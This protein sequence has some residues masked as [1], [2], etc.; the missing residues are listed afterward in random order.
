[1]V[2]TPQSLDSEDDSTHWTSSHTFS[3]IASPTSHANGMSTPIPPHHYQRAAEAASSTSTMDRRSTDSDIY[4]PA[5]DDTA[6]LYTTKHFNSP[7]SPPSSISHYKSNDTLFPPTSDPSAHL[8]S[9]QPYSLSYQHLPSNVFDNFSDQTLTWDAF[10][11][12]PAFADIID[13]KSFFS[14]SNPLPTPK[15]GSINLEESAPLYPEMNARDMENGDSMLIATGMS[16]LQQAC[17]HG[18]EIVVQLLLTKGA[19]LDTKDGNGQ[20]T[21]HI[22]ARQGRQSVTKLLLDQGAN[23]F[24]QDNFG[25]TPLHVASR[26]GHQSIVRLLLEG[27]GMDR[28]SM[29][30][31][32]FPD[33]HGR[34]ALH[35]ASE[36]GHAAVV[37]LLVDRGALVNTRSAAGLT[38]LHKAAENGQDSVVR[39]L[40][41]SGADVNAK[42]GDF[43]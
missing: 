18:H 12:D 1:M 33:I 41:E 9:H 25:Q 29:G 14:E 32:E 2:Y 4:L 37:K 23:Q 7:P 42:A 8:Q 40:L 24:I 35:V 20:T 15:S 26:E 19:E 3:G 27:P 11:N 13:H 36:N 16:A 28:A 22:A 6:T 31:L 5:M 34:T 38:A 17:F 10:E 21:L 30:V 43:G 39:L